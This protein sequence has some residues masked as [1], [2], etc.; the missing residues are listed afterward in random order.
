[1]GV[2]ER[3]ERIKRSA[4][5]A[6]A[7]EV[8]GAPP[9]SSAA[10]PAGGSRRSS[11]GGYPE[12]PDSFL[13]DYLNGYARPSS[14]LQ[15]QKLIR[16]VESAPG[17]GT[18]PYK[19]KKG[20][21]HRYALEWHKD[22]SL[23]DNLATPLAR[24]GMSKEDLIKAATEEGTEEALM[25]M[26]QGNQ[27]IMGAQFYNTNRA[28]NKAVRGVGQDLVSDN[29]DQRTMALGAMGL[30]AKQLQELYAPGSA[31]VPQDSTGAIPEW[32]PHMKDMPALQ[33]GLAYG[34]LAAGAGAAT[35]VTANLLAQQ[36]AQQ[37]ANGAY[38]SLMQQ[39]NAY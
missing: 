26:M 1:M 30:D 20:K 38:A 3:L 4:P 6:D 14:W 29:A 12:D 9:P 37:Q 33:T 15:N 13:S 36:G 34:A 39:M 24:M 22:Q 11:R 10:P 17:F 35:L 28:V 27:S 31:P 8:G 25:R 18:V 21:E 5:R 7:G 16:A 32:V 19:D 2:R 23:D